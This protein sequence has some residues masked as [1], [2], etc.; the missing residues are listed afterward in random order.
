[1]SDHLAEGGVAFV[2]FPPYYSPYGGHQQILPRRKIGFVPYNKLPYIQLLPDALFKRIVAGDS[3]ANDEVERLR[4]VRLTLKRFA[5]GTGRAGFEISRRKL[6]LSR[7]TF[8][9]RYGMPVIGASFL[10]RIPLV[11]ELTTTA[12]YFLLRKR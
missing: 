7:S 9:L 6:Y 11:N 2:V 5:R 4:G 10:G 1:M 12:A 3:P 8:S